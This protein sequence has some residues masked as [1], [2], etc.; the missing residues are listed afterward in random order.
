MRVL[1]AGC[2]YVGSVLASDLA[3][4]GDE[5]FGLRRDPSSLPSAV[6][7]IAADLCAPDTLRRVPR[8][9]DAVVYAVSADAREDSAYRRAYVE[10]VERLCAVVVPARFVFVSSASVYGQAG[11]EWVDEDSPTEPRAF[12]GRRVLEGE[13]LAR[14]APGGVAIRFGGIYGPGRTRL[15]DSVADGRARWRPQHFTNRIHRDDCAGALRHLLDLERPE[16]LYVGVDREP[17]EEQAVLAW[18]AH[19]AGVE[20]PPPVEP[21]AETRGVGSKRCS[22][23]RLV[24]SGYGFRYPTFRDGYAALGA[25]PERS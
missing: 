24:E 8:D 18:L 7:P 9:L 2:G 22:S 1:I 14:S 23:R 17:C 25:D 6:T 16:S 20:A 11:G 19:R 21:G 5:V 15:R 10:G 12:S 13:R 3:A 4:R